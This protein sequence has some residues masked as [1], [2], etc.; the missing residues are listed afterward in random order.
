MSNIPPFSTVTAYAAALVG[1]VKDAK[2]DRTDEEFIEDA[3]EVYN[4][5]YTA[6]QTA[7][8]G[9]DS[10]K[11]WQL[12]KAAEPFADFLLGYSDLFPLEVEELDENDASQNPRARVVSGW[13]L[14]ERVVSSVPVKFIMFETA[15]AS[16]SKVRVRWRAQWAAANV[17]VAHQRSVV[18]FAAE[19]KC[20]ALESRYR[21]T[22]D[23]GTGFSGE[24]TADGYAS[25]ASRWRRKAL[26][27]LGIGGGGKVVARGSVVSNRER[28]F[29]RGI[30]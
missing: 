22:V 12:G 16:T 18:Y 7:D 15:P 19:L 4:D 23:D 3:L 20:L 6:W 10:T 24:V 30:P 11:E 26:S 5:H 2:S 28:V 8:I 25:A 21:S 29:Y 17:P 1:L 14:D 13:R 27:K 9:D